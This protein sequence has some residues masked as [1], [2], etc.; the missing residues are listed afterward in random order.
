M[1]GDHLIRA[2]IE[3]GWV[4]ETPYLRV[5][6][7]W[8]IIGRFLKG[9]YASDPERWR[10]IQRVYDPGPRSPET[11]QQLES[12]SAQT[13]DKLD[14]TVQNSIIHKSTEY[15][16]QHHQT[17]ETNKDD[18]GAV[19]GKLPETSQ[20]DLSSLK[21]E[22]IRSCGMRRISER[23]DERLLDLLKRHGPGVAEACQHLHSGIDNVVGYLT[24]IL[25][26]TD[27]NAEMAKR[28]EAILRKGGMS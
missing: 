13:V 20:T 9:R 4:D 5:H 16:L 18:D 12:N 2:L 26:P 8:S 27:D 10:G 6:D 3:S 24:K 23:E 21:R 17:P 1:N 15:H 28:V 11:S 7:W 14:D 19:A 25:D 22:I